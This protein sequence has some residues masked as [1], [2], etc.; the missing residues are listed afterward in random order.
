MGEL[1]LTT[2]DVRGTC[3]DETLGAVQ[4]MLSPDDGGLA[5][6]RGRRGN[7][8]DR[9]RVDTVGFGTLK[10]GNAG[11]LGASSSALANVTVQS[12]MVANNS[13]TDPAAATPSS[14][15]SRPSL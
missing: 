5:S 1:S 2:L 15:R 11:A 10:L 8:D 4:C 6:A 14:L 7:E 3:V 13:T 9:D 12:S